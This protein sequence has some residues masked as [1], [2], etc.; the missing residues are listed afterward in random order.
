MSNPLP[1]PWQGDA[2]PLSYIRST[3]R[4]LSHPDFPWGQLRFLRDEVNLRSGP[5]ESNPRI[6]GGNLVPNAVRPGPQSSPMP[7]WIQAALT[8]GPGATRR[9]LRIPD[10]LLCPP[11]DGFAGRAVRPRSALGART[12]I[13]RLRTG[14]PRPVGG[15]RHETFTIGGPYEYR[16]RLSP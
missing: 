8:K 13:A 1:S 6:Q 3:A 16:S 2:L 12:P 5:R 9:I 15:M 10:F 7:S 11:H 4:M 14:S